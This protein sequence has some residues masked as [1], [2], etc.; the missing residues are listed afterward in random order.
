MSG[1]P[2]TPAP[3]DPPND[4]TAG[5]GKTAAP[6]PE[7][8]ETTAPAPDATETAASARDATETAAPAPDVSGPVAS[9]P[10]SARTSTAPAAV[11]PSTDVSTS[12]QATEQPGA[13]PA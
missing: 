8:S 10:G 5:T 9:E 6:A 1:T 13:P 11:L 12:G 3:A 2:T 7:S 4:T